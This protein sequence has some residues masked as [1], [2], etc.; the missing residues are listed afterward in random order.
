MQSAIYLHCYAEMKE[1]LLDTILEDARIRE[2]DDHHALC[3]LPDRLR[4]THVIDKMKRH[5]GSS[6]EEYI[7]PVECLIESASH[8]EVI[9]PQHTMGFAKLGSF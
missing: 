2:L 4:R 9:L 8:I 6:K 7:Q 1:K 3:I 5:T